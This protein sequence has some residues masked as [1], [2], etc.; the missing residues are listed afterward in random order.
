MRARKGPFAV[1]VAVGAGRL[2]ALAVV[3][4][5]A[6]YGV[7]AASAA[8]GGATYSATQTIA[9]PPA[10]NFAGSAGGDGW[11]VALSSTAV[12][13]IFHHQGVMYVACHLQSNASVCPGVGWP[14][15]VSDPGGSAYQT[16]GQPGMYLDQATGKLYS[17]ET[18]ASDQTAGV[19]C[20]DTNAALA[21][22]NPFCGF[23]ALSGTGE[24]SAARGA[25][26]ISDPM[27]VGNYW[28][29]FNYQDGLG[30]GPGA[31][32]KLLCFDL[33]TDAAC[34]GQ[35]F[36]VD[37]GSGT[38]SYSDS[39]GA[40]SVSPATALI[41]TELVIPVQVGG[42]DSL[43]CFDG[44]TQSSCSGSWPIVSS[45]AFGSAAVGGFAGSQGYANQFGAPF[46][47]LS[48]AGQVTGFCLP[49]GSDPCFGLDGSSIATPNGMTGVVPATTPWEGPAVTIG[50][51]I[52]VPV[53]TA[54]Y[55][56][57]N[58]DHVACYDYSTSSA[59]AGFSENFNGS[60]SL[61]YTVNPDP[62]RPTCL[63]VNA[64][65]GGSQIQNFDAYTG[66]PC[67]SGT[68]RVLTS[69][70][71]VPQAQC[72]PTAYQS[73]KVDS[74]APG[75]YT[76]GQVQFA[77][78]G[79]NPLT[80]IP[81][82][83]LDSTG[84]ADLTGLGLSTVT[85]LP[86]YLITLTGASTTQLT[87]TLTWTAAYDPACA[88]SGTSV[89][90]AATT[91]SASI[92]ASDGQTGSTLTVAPGTS[93]TA[94]ASIAGD[95][96]AGASGS[97][98]YTWYS[99][100]ACST[101]AATD[102]ETIAT[103][104]TVPS[105]AP[106]T[107]DVGTYYLVASYGGDAGNSASASTCGDAVLTVRNPDT[108]PPVTTDNAP[109]GWSNS[110][111]TVTLTATDNVG[112]SGVAST[113]YSVD[114]GPDQVGTTVTIA[115]PADHSND[116]T[117]TITY[118]S[119]DNAGNTETPHS[120]TVKIDTTPPALSPAVSPDPVA[121][122]AS[123]TAS[124]NATDSLSGVASASC[125][126]V[127]T[128]AY[129]DFTVT[130]TATDNAGN[131]A[132]GTASYSVTVQATKQAI[133]AEIKAALASASKHDREALRR[134]ADVLSASLN[135][136]LWVDGNHPSSKRVFELEV[137]AASALGEL[138]HDRH[139]AVNGKT[140]QGWIDSLVA[141]DRAL[142]EIAIADATAGGA[143]SRA[144]GRASKE[145][146]AGDSAASHRDAESAIEHYGNAWQELARVANSHFRRTGGGDYRDAGGSHA[147]G[148]RHSKSSSHNGS[149]R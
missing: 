142:A 42:V 95:N 112:G 128:S 44:A 77:D 108:T 6:L 38:M 126:S 46:P 21:G 145:V 131:T 121:Q 57:T 133:L 138:G 116:G 71:V 111:V 76:S 61:L 2:V 147:G 118:Y 87:V 109:S 17:F 99:D 37:F 32:N 103:P 51:R 63:W 134:A 26:P 78:G 119:V 149:N 4:L 43:A 110:A 91:T 92:S 117:H 127:D 56:N 50:S 90:P 19:V 69:Q 27:R 49:D 55:T 48:S 41:G 45:N 140:V 144:L 125:G 85:G 8:T 98:T 9:V 66:G 97:V 80:S 83:A 25:S 36:A 82:V 15:D 13:N 14:Y 12:F 64:N 122:G 30:A 23:T 73:L 124:A 20:F 68:T 102:T 52:Y 148:D 100:A 62:Q 75:S 53:S 11:A 81:A 96:A 93:E 24:S 107:L 34:A 84:T 29:A 39:N 135:P 86:Q 1:R 72:Y 7:A 60:L 33:S 88:T 89:V 114:G 106:A 70:F 59:C 67:G 58:A 113:Y 16:S 28:Y 10:S 40:S 141:D 101:V 132:T 120:T 79:G 129:G 136:K 94:S 35:P 104:G 54:N 115:A 31:Q 137:Q 130:C 18:R 139:S 105:S 65:G 146:S 5:I 74:P 123:A 22:S 3:M 47:V 143:S